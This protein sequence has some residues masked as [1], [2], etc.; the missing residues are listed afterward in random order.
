MHIAQ[1]NWGVL[2]ADWDDPKVAEFVDNI[3]RVNA[4]ADRFP[5]FIWRLGDD[6]MEAE[7][8]D[9]SGPIDWCDNARV[10][11]TLSVWDSVA[12][13]KSFAFKGVH[14][15]FWRR[16]PEWLTGLPDWPR[17][18]L[19]RVPQGHRPTVEE[20]AL[21]LK[22]LKSKGPTDHAF[23]FVWADAHLV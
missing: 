17:N 21:R 1:F 11:S 4:I 16:G 8:L 15:T 14:A 3:D 18:V 13:L 19:W 5:G 2:R 20:G 6:A 12:A 23:D 9:T 7:Q 10:A 22:H